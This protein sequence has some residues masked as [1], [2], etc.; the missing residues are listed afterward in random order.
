MLIMVEVEIEVPVEDATDEQIQEWL[1][2]QLGSRGRISIKNP[3]HDQ[4]I[5]AHCVTY[6]GY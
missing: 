2:F 1:E 6:R 4:D 3:L 5:E